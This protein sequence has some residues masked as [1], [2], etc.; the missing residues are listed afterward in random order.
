MIKHRPKD[1]T[2]VNIKGV[3]YECIN[4][5]V[6]LPKAYKQFNPIQEKKK[7]EDKE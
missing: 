7:K 5:I 2:N 1:K 4:G 3:I 6:E